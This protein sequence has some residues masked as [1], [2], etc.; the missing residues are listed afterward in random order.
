MKK[1][2]VSGSG[3]REKNKKIKYKRRKELITL[4]ISKKIKKKI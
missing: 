4:K 3:G 2:I 1:M